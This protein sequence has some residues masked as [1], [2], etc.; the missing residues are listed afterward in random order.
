MTD[1][2]LK[3]DLENPWKA[4]LSEIYLSGKPP[5]PLGTVSPAEIE[6]LAQEKLK[7]HPGAFMYAGGSAGT[8]QTYRANLKYFDKFFIIPRMLRDSTKRNLQTTLFGKILPSPLILAPIGVQSIFHPD[9][10]SASARAAGKLKI[11]YAMSTAA[12]RTIEEVAEANG[13]DSERWFQLYWPKSDEITLSL[14]SRAKAA[15]FSA[16]IVTLDT[17]IIGWRPHDLERAYLPFRHGLGVQVGISDPVFMARLRKQPITET[18]LQ[19]PYDTVKLDK[20]FA[21]GD[22][23]AREFVHLG[24][25]WMKEA[26]SGIYR[27]WEDLKLLRD[28][29]EGPLILKGIQCAEDAEKALEYGIDGILVSNHGGRQVDGAV[30]ALWSLENIMKSPVIREAQSSGK[31][32]VLFDSG[33]RTGADIIKAIAIGAQAVLL[34]RPVVYGSVLGGQE[35]IEQVIRHTLADLDTSLG[36]AGYKNLSEIHGKADTVLTRL[37][38]H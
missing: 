12:T 38:L 30:P 11:P 2:N 18:K 26:N 33:I 24:I 28:N 5:H 9:G 21:D 34:G 35:G 25:E 15:G 17:T 1:L 27:T 32:T 29:W 19:M 22:A 8:N 6:I 7:E 23:E 10:E 13:P 14:L 16:L 37:D 31:V 36:L 4:L 3:G 20:A